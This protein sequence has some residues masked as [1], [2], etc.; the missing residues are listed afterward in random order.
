MLEK[1]FD[2]A[3]SAALFLFVT[4]PFACVEQETDLNNKF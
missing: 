3:I 4:S 1:E 2:F